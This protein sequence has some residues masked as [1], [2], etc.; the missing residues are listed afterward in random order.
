MF[1]LTPNVPPEV[2]I[3]LLEMERLWQKGRGDALDILEDLNAKFPIPD[4]YP[5]HHSLVQLPNRA[6]GVLV[7]IVKE[8]G[9]PLATPALTTPD[10]YVVGFE[11]VLKTKG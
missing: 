3:P 1:A 10:L 5:R 9:D 8:V 4:G 11:V 2:W 6:L 7:N